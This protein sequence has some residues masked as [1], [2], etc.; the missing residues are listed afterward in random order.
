MTNLQKPPVY[1]HILPRVLETSTNKKCNNDKNTTMKLPLSPPPLSKQTTRFPEYNVPSNTAKERQSRVDRILEKYRRQPSTSVSRQYSRSLSCNTTF[2]PTSLIEPNLLL[3][4]QKLNEE[5]KSNLETQSVS[6]YASVDRSELASTATTHRENKANAMDNSRLSKSYSLRSLGDYRTQTSE[7]MSLVDD[8]VA[9][10]NNGTVVNNDEDPP[11][12]A[13]SSTTT[14]SN[15][16]IPKE[17]I[18][19]FYCYPSL[20]DWAVGN[21][22]EETVSDRIRRRSFYVKL[23]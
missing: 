9:S 13:S 15:S 5:N 6:P 21:C 7:S 4:T 19:N 2:E 14:T 18:N 3:I 22:S 17:D 10:K 11:S 1:K 20:M 12:S 23:K 8:K 16:A